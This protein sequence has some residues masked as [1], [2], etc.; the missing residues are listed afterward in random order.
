MSRFELFVAGS[1]QMRVSQKG[2]QILS[3]QSEDRRGCTRLGEL[4]ARV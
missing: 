1:V 4:E 2:L 3:D